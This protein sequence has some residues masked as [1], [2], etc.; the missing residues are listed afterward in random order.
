[1]SY[2]VLIV[3]DSAIVR[4]MVKR[5]LAMV[6]IE[7]NEHHEASNGLEALKVLSSA[8]IDIVFADLNMPEM[9]GAELVAK[10]TE[11]DMLVSTPVVIVSSE[12]SE[13]RIEE[14]KRSGIRAYIRKPFRPES[15]KVVV[16][17]VLRT[18]EGDPDDR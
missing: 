11:D 3:D 15:F 5:S 1:L 14:L 6:G 10:M 17:D 12:H 7:V 2:N 4:A 8:W 18:A 13:A 9:G 16:T